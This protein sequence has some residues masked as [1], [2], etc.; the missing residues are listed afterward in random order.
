MDST[1]FT[2]TT[3]RAG[4]LTVTVWPDTP[5]GE[6]QRY[7]YRID[8][9][10]TGRTLE[11]RD[12]FT[13]TGEPV[14]PGTALRELAAYLTAAGQARQHTTAYPDAAGEHPGLFPTWLAEAARQNAGPLAGLA[15]LAAP[16]APA[17][18]P[19]RWV[20]VVFLQGT[21]A[22]D[23]LDLV[24]RDGP[25]A[26]IAHLAGWDYGDETTDAAMVNGYVY[27]TPPTGALDQTATAGA[28]VLTYNHS[29]GHVG[30]LR[31]L[32]TPPDPAL[33]EPHPP[34]TA[35]PRPAGR[36]AS[37]RE[38]RRDHGAEWFAPSPRTGAPVRGLAL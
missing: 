32:T 1:D 33:D 12:L 18:V 2:R 25:D 26:A 27:D 15:G 21:E 28:Y 10:A 22:D 29:L 3:T 19:R 24:D 34:H 17:A 7:A 38:P 16:P 14:D 13:G 4:T 37:V 11:G 30:L 23:V 20:S 8:D 36:A 9:A 35:G 5:L 31:E 6:H